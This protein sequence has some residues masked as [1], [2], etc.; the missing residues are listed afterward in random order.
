[1]EPDFSER[2][3]FPG[4]TGTPFDVFLHSLANIERIPLVFFIILLA[5]LSLVPDP[6]DWQL[7][8]AHLVFFLVDWAL[9]ASLPHFHKSYG[10]PKPVVLVLAILRTF[11]NLLPPAISIPLQV[12]G[13]LLVVYGFW[14]EPHY[15]R[16]TKQVFL[17]S[18]L[19]KGTSIRILHLSDLH[20][21]R[22]TQREQQ[23][24][25]Y[26][27]DLQPDMILYSG[28]FIN[29]SYLHD[30]LA[31]ED[32][33]KVMSDWSAPFGVFAVTGSPAVDLPEIIPEL[34]S[35]SSLYWLRN[36]RK[37]VAVNDQEIEIMGVNC[38][39]KPFLDEQS[40]KKVVE[41][42]S[43]RF[44]VFLYHSPDLAPATSR[45]NVDLQLSGHTHGGQ[46]RLP[47]IGAVF[48]GSLY[49]RRFQKGRYK[50]GNLT[51]YISRG[52]GM[53]GAGAP[54]VRFLCPPEIIL[55]EITGTGVQ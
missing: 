2:R 47:F 28:D 37:V 13:I 55:W 22:I 3:H 51:L 45:Y 32:A 43:P 25:R 30:P 6:Y 31:W 50:L 7:D 52:M 12:V 48:T 41:P 9:L 34:T 39:H 36:E 46:V 17:T 16:L 24:S 23:L 19:R 14:I 5:F 42:S 54:R 18:K 44:R 35:G 20:V 33:R 15:L 29:L 8:L 40:L 49:G 26:I 38:S 10:N 53:E 27:R 21:E 1:M 4:T 11:V